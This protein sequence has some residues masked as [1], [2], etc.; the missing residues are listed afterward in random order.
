MDMNTCSEELNDK[1][2]EMKKDVNEGWKWLSNAK[3]WHY[4][5]GAVS[6]C[7]R[8]FTFSLG[9]LE[10]GLDDSPDNCKACMRKLK[11]HRAEKREKSE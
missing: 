1:K 7:G 10:Q 2:R 6:L 4:F 5:I 9:D 11:V 8:W 3:K